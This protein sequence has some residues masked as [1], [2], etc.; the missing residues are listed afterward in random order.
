MTGQENNSGQTI[1][2][3]MFFRDGTS[4]TVIQILVSRE[5]SDILF[6]AYVM[7]ESS[8]TEMILLEHYGSYGS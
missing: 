7:S 8:H 1:H 4:D 3:S 6:T 5:H 2:F